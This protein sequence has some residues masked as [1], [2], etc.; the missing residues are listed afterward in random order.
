MKK[1]KLFLF[2]LLAFLLTACAAHTRRVPPNPANP[3]FTLAVLPM[4]NATNDVGGPQM[5]RAEIAKRLARYHYQVMPVAEVNKAL[6]NQMG[7]T[8]GDQLEQTTPEEVGSVLGVDGLVYGW[9]VNF[10]DVTTGI[11]NV[12]KVRA[13]FKLV[14]TGSGRVFWSRGLGVKSLIA[15]GDVGV[16]ISIFKELKDPQT[17]LI[18]SIEGL[19]DIPGIHTWHIIRAGGTENVGEAAAIAIGEKLITKALKIHLKLETDVMLNHLMTS[20]P[21]GPGSP[22]T[23]D[24]ERYRGI[25]PETGVELNRQH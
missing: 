3:V 11:Y 2:V 5:V 13:G 10:D 14:E 20:F 22:V 16:G 18:N 8:L 21:P 25:G 4:Y 23:G 17:D 1:R 15:G 24:F 9:L 6:Q 7:I 12:K 19:S